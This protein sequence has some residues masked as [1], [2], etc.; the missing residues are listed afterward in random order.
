MTSP[1]PA[2]HDDRPRCDWALSAPDYVAYHDDEWGRPVHGTAAWFERMS[3]EAFQSGLSWIVVLRKRPAFREVFAGFDPDT[4]ARFGDDDVARLLG[5][6]RIV[7][8]R[9]KIEATISNA[10]AVLDLLDAGDDLG[11]FLASPAPGTAVRRPRLHARVDGVV[12]GAQEARLPVRRSHHLLR[13]HAGDRSGR[14]PRRVLLACR[15]RPGGPAG[16]RTGVAVASPGR[17]AA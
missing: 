4:V 10:R 9:M 15:G 16:D 5:D 3:L 2:A 11:A 1:D 17:C 7:R 6:A 14:R 8:N 13:T 12:D